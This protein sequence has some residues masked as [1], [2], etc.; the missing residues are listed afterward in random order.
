M[1]TKNYK[2]TT[3]RPEIIYRDNKPVSV[4]IDLEDYQQMLERLEDIEDL[5]F[6]NSVKT[7]SLKFRKLDDFLL[8]YNSNV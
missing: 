1:I 8:E 6:I 3:K 2:L 7:K 5:R 4:I